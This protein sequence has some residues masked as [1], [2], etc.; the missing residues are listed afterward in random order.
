MEQ[1]YSNTLVSSRED[2]KLVYT[3]NIFDKTYKKY[4]NEINQQLTEVVDQLKDIQDNLQ[5]TDTNKSLSANQ[6]RLLKKL[7]DA[8]IVQVQGAIW[9]S[10]PTKGN[11][12]HLIS[13]D[14]LYEKFKA[15]NDST[16]Y[17]TEDEFNALVSEGL[18]KE[19]VNYYIYE[20]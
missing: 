8:K 2:K 20:E 5:S 1:R 15:I 16:V 12:D 7:I 18:I 19:D 11:V 4:Q 6:G 14:V 3:D 9:D 13:S 10:E 17:L